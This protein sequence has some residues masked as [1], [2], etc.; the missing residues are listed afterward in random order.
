MGVVDTS[1]S[2]TGTSVRG[3]AV[4]VS[5]LSIGTYGVALPT[6]WHPGGQSSPSL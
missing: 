6:T 2:L 3:G 5:E 4:P 1:L